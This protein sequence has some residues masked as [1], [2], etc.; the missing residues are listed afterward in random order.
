M[1]GGV[2]DD[3]WAGSRQEIGS[4]GEG[5]GPYR[6]RSPKSARLFRRLQFNTARVT[7]DHQQVSKARELLRLELSLAEGRTRRL[8]P[9]TDLSL[10]LTSQA[11]EIY[12]SK[13]S[14][15]LLYFWRL[16][17]TQGHN[18]VR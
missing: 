3:K 18:E 2:S 4:F 16:K 13:W 9:T 14:S 6:A 7:T 17:S 10:Q 12:L 5:V 8:R 1:S 11:V 15:Q